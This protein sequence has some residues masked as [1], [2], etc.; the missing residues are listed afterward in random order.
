VISSKAS[1]D[2]ARELERRD[3]LRSTG[4][5]EFTEKDLAKR[6]KLL[7]KQMFEHAKSLEF[8]QAARIRDQLSQL[9]VR[10]FGA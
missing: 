1:K 3:M 2:A 5:E 4:V 7:E 9:K 8:E 10:A 6:I